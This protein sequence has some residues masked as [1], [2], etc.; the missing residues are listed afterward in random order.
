MTASTIAH[1][2]ITLDHVKPAV[3]RRVEVPV[4]IRLDRLHLVFQAALG[5]TNSH[6]TEIRARDV[7][8]GRVDPDWGDGPLDAAKSRLIDVIEDTSAKTLKY[9]YDF[10]D[11]WEHT[12]KIERIADAVPGRQ[13]PILIDATGRCP[14]EDVGGPWGY[15]DLLKILADPRHERYT[16]MT[17]WVGGAFDPLAMKIADHT[18]AV[19]ALA[20][21]WARMPAVKRKPTK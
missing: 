3:Q 5:W 18:K 6:L 12:V 13:Y 2:K 11:G 20:R 8:W 10:G 16:E 1:L 21:K 19:D 14:P 15:S 17:E 9:L 4:T 7:S